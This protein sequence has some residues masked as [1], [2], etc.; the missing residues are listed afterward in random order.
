MSILERID[1]I[2]AK[3]PLDH[4]LLD[5]LAAIKTQIGHDYARNPPEKEQKEETNTPKGESKVLTGEKPERV[6]G[7]EGI[8][9]RLKW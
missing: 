7:I 5:D 9:R 8:K 2:I 6:V 3:H 1:K 4:E